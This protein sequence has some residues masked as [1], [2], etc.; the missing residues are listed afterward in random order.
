VLSLHPLSGFFMKDPGLCAVAGRF[1][2]SDAYDPVFAQGETARGEYWDLVG[3]ILTAAHLYRLALDEQQQKR[4]VHERQ[5]DDEAMVAPA[6]RSIAG[7]LEEF[8]AARG[9]CC[10]NCRGHVCLDERTSSPGADGDF[11]AHYT[12][13]ACDRGLALSITEGELSQWLAS[14]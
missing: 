2:A 11:R 9:V 13:R 10:P 3:A 12:C 4:G 8:A 6:E 7:L 1:F 14:R 5:P